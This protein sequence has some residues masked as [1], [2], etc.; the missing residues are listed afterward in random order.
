MLPDVRW[1]V[2]VAP[3]TFGVVDVPTPRIVA[4]SPAVITAGASSR[5]HVRGVHF[6]WGCVL[7]WHSR[8]ANVTLSRWAGSTPAVVE[9]A[10]PFEFSWASEQA[11]SF[12]APVE[13]QLQ[14]VVLE[15]LLPEKGVGSPMAGALRAGATISVVARPCLAEGPCQIC[16]ASG[17]SG[18]AFGCWNIS[19]RVGPCPFPASRCAG[20]IQCACRPEYVGFECSDCADR[21]FRV[22]AACVACDLTSAV[23]TYVTLGVASATIVAVSL[24]PSNAAFVG[25]HKVLYATQLLVFA[26][27]SLGENAKV[28]NSALL[29]IWS[30][31]SY[32]CLNV[33]ALPLTCL[34]TLGSSFG[35][36]FGTQLLVA[37]A[38]FLPAIAALG[39]RFALAHRVHGSAPALRRDEGGARIVCVCVGA[40]DLLVMPALSLALKALHCESTAAGVRLAAQHSVQCAS[41]VH[42][43]VIA[44]ALALLL[45]AGAVYPA[46]LL[47]H[48]RSQLGRRDVRS[49]VGL[50]RAAFLWATYAD[51]FTVPALVT[52]H[53][54]R[55]SLVVLGLWPE[56]ATITRV[57]V[58]SLSLACAL[59]CA[60]VGPMLIARANV[61]A[62]GTLCLVGASASVK[63]WAANAPNSEAPTATLLGLLCGAIALR[64]TTLV[65]ACMARTAMPSAAGKD[66]AGEAVITGTAE[67][68]ADRERWLCP[69]C[70]EY[71]TSGH[72]CKQHV[73]TLFG[74]ESDHSERGSSSKA[75]PQTCVATSRAAACTGCRAGCT[76]SGARGGQAQFVTRQ[77]RRCLR[78]LV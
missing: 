75:R 26:A 37:S 30:V 38:L 3:L 43:M 69:G 61:A 31:A 36:Y 40:A 51:R 49:E 12:S 6:E 50:Q 66:G 44:A 33:D 21:H 23:L 65:Y 39:L 2:E 19:D 15:V 78:L 59:A 28:G 55:V 67:L 27:G 11:M 9:G 68:P 16:D 42:A 34:L 58:I 73:V 7:M 63:L 57:L 17:A 56:D 53:L 77:R 47:S 71:G 32:L 35:A 5:V 60:L 10:G 8:D 64:T 14:Q 72:I 18:C 48:A 22:G 62:C 41:A 25:L 24:L 29:A 54:L 74:L 76:G 1:S 13:A 70:H 52:R 46:W 45:A 20:G 4:L